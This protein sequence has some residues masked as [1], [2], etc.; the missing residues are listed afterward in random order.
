MFFVAV[1]VAAAVGS[2]YVVM[3]VRSR[4]FRARFSVRCGPDGWST[5]TRSSTAA[6]RAIYVYARN[7][8]PPYVFF[9]WRVSRPQR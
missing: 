6:A 7:L 2:L 5:H 1:A 8:S 4:R 3:G 9:S